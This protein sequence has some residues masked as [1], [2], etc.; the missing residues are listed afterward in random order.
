MLHHVG[1]ADPPLT[2]EELVSAHSATARVSGFIVMA[3][4]PLHNAFTDRCPFLGIPFASV[5]G[6]LPA[7]GICG[8][9]GRV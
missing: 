8:I 3:R 1:K 5:R 4:F 9:C 6:G 2:I 7:F